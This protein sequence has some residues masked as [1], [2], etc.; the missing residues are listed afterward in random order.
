MDKLYGNR[1][2]NYINKSIKTSK[3]KILFIAFY[4]YGAFG[5]RSIQSFVRSKGYE[6]YTI[7]FK[8]DVANRILEP[9]DNEKEMLFDRIRLFCPNIICISL[10]SPQFKVVSKINQRT[11]SRR[12]YH[13]GRDPRNY[14]PGGMYRT[15]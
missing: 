1:G 12:N 7:F 10:R 15:C 14:M 8:E 9:T 5:I 3:P 11:V 13:M 2:L 6:T 4:D